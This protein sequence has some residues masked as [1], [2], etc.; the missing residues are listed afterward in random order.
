MREAVRDAGI[1]NAAY[2]SAF[3]GN[4]SPWR[5]GWHSYGSGAPRLPRCQH[6]DDSHKYVES[7]RKRREQPCWTSM[8]TGRPAEITG[9]LS[10]LRPLLKIC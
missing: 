7:R 6:Y 5:P 8:L 4:P 2:D 1:T 10:S 9:R 3:I